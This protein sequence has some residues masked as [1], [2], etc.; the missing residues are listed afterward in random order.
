[1]AFWYLAHIAGFTL[2]LGGG[3]AA[4]LV[5]IRSRQEDRAIQGVLVRYL[6]GIHRLLMLPGIVLTLASGVYL[7]IP[8]AE[9]AAPNAW[10]MVMQLAGVLAAILVLFISL[11]TLARLNRISPQGDTA[12]LFDAL[13]KRQAMAGMIAGNL[14]LLA[15]LGGVLF[16]Y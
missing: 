13:R 14:G 5:G 6:T 9:Q 8:A 3:L 2:W 4:M 15:L 11:P 1:M 16:K 7:S 12:P 10:L